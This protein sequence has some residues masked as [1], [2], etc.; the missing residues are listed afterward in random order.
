M[1]WADRQLPL[2]E[3][4]GLIILSGAGSRV[5]EQDA[6]HPF[7]LFQF[8][9]KTLLYFMADSNWMLSS[10]GIYCINSEVFLL[11]SVEMEEEIFLCFLHFV[12]YG[13]HSIESASIFPGLF[14]HLSVHGKNFCII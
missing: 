1:H 2:K 8:I 12:S 9:F 4:I 7:P 3:D 14:I 11:I 10:S 13:I 6:I 5:F